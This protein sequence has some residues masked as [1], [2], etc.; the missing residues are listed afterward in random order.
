MRKIFYEYN[1]WWEEVLDLS[2][3]ILREKYLS[4]IRTFLK[5]KGIL[6][7]TGLRRVGK[8]TLLKLIID[9]LIKSSVNPSRIF[10]VSLDDY[11]LRSVSIVELVNEYRKLHKLKTSNFIYLFFDEITYS[12]D[13]QQQLKNLYDLGN[14]KIVATSSSCSLLRDKKAYLT[15]RTFTIEVNP[16]DF[17]EYL[18]FKRVNI[19]MRDS[20][21]LESFFEEFMRV[22]GLPENVLNPSRE[23]LMNLVDD[24]IQKDITAFYGL[25]NH[26]ILRD[27]FTLLMERSGKQ[28]SI[29]K[30]AN[31]LKISPDT[32]R[33][34]LQYFEW[35]YLVHLLP[36]WGTTNE[37]LLS[38]KK[39]YACDL[40]IKYLFMGD[41]DRGSYFENYVY[42]QLRNKTKVY[43][44]YKNGNEIDFFTEAK[45][46]IEAKY[47]SKM[48]VA[49]ERLFNEY[50]AKKKVLI[51]SVEKLSLINETLGIRNNRDS[52][53]F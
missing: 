13:Y 47:Y 14:V 53:I 36:R 26:E 8:T 9:E 24:I 33:R 6:F 31:I 46:L 7:L 28:F 20:H 38:A 34:Y 42:L 4:S 12:Q 16:L 1:P 27:F 22:G 23:Y 40:G 48:S 43:Y 44:I 11:L 19:K 52:D 35:T 10:Y 18:L 25:K 50:P 5:K 49:Q 21:L 37:K 15:G 29:N 51:D 45:V 41:R 39:V 3:I 32:A 30:I 2:D 17:Q